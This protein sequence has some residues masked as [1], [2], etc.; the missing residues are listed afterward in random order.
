[1]GGQEGVELAEPDDSGA[2]AL[3][4]DWEALSG[5][6][7][8]GRASSPDPGALRPP[9]RAGFNGIFI[10]SLNTFGKSA[11]NLK[12]DSLQIGLEIFPANL[13]YLKSALSLKK[14]LVAPVAA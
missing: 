10:F 4:C 2:S 8:L 7:G 12:S 1:F 14:N 9:E 13:H 6:S 3:V 5:R 11:K